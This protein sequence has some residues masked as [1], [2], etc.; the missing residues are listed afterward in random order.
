MKLSI[1]I[2]SYNVKYYLEQCLYSLRKACRNTEV[3]ILVVDNASSDGTVDYIRGNFPEVILIG[4]NENLGFS[5]A[6]NMAIRQS[7]GEYVL[8][9]NP[10]TIVG[11]HV[12]DGCVD[13]LDT[14]PEAG[15]TGVAMLKDD[16]G[17]AWESRRGLPT[18]LLLFAR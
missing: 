7:K 11:E 9:L 14:H 15:A 3:E 5:R 6:N 1:V 12:L 18:P 17:F 10:D 8:L 2:V 13:F 4:N 16:G